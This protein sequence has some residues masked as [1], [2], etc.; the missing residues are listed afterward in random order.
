LYEAFVT[1]AGAFQQHLR[2]VSQAERAHRE[3]RR[4]IGERSAQLFAAVGLA[5]NAG[6]DFTAPTPGLVVNQRYRVEEKLG[7]GGM[8]VV[9]RVTRLEDQSRWAMKVATTLSP[10]QL[11]RLAREAHLLSCVRHP[12]I[13]QIVDIDV[14][15]QGFLFLVLELVDGT[16]LHDW[17]EQRPG[18]ELEE[19]L[20]ILAQVARGLRR[21]HDSRIAHRDLKPRN[22]LLYADGPRLGV[23]LA[24]FGVARLDPGD[25]Q[26]PVPEHPV[27]HVAAA[28][29]EADTR[30]LSRPPGPL[31]V[32]LESVVHSEAGRL[33]AEPALG[34]PDLLVPPGGATAETPLT[35]G[36][37]GVTQSG[38]IVGTLKY[39]APEVLVGSGSA[40]AMEADLFSFGVV[41]W[42]LV[43]GKGPFEGGA[44]PREFASARLLGEAWTQLGSGSPELDALVADCLACE[45]GLRPTSERA[46]ERLEALLTSHGISLPG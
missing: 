16:N 5:R 8:G 39:L 7:E 26:G 3:L 22:I 30:V 38:V 18:V 37:L 2:S 27:A 24:D 31:P 46:S 35:P 1:H 34:P 9:F 33:V 32:T 17:R 43:A 44:S 41:A 19:A 36:V 42:E 23:K 12:H 25:P 14:A 45:P 15:T 28:W 10:A 11:A 13:V 20:V 40:S 4:Q 21:L 6:V 29:Q